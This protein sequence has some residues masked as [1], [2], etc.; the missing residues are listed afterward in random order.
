MYSKSISIE[1]PVSDYNESYFQNITGLQFILKTVQ[2]TRAK[3]ISVQIFYLQSDLSLY[4]KLS[5]SLYG[6]F[7]KKHSKIFRSK[8]GYF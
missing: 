6:L 1:S 4:A 7:C 5:D 3:Y 2:C 8:K